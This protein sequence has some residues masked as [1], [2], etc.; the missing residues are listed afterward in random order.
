MRD[1]GGPLGV[2]VQAQILNHLLLLRSRG[3]V[4]SEQE[5]GWAR[6]GQV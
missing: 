5:K 2:G 1:E 6:P 4:V 3:A